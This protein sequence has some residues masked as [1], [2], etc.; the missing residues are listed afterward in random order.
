Q[1]HGSGMVSYTIQ[2]R[3]GQASGTQIKAQARVLFN[4]T[5]PQDTNEITD[6]IDGQAPVTTLTATPLT[7]GGSDYQGQGSAQDDAGGSGVKHVTVYVAADGGDFKIWQRQ[8][9]QTSA[10]YNGPAGHT[11]QFL[12][13]ATDNAG[14]REKPPPMLL[15]PDDGS[16]PNLGTVPNVGQTSQDIPLSP[17]PAPAPQP[18]TTPL[19]VEAQRGIPGPPPA[20]GASE[21]HSVLRPFVGSA[22]ATGFAQSEPDLEP[23]TVAPLPDGSEITSGGP[24]IGPLAIAPLPDGSALVSGGAWRNQLFH[25]PRVGGAVGAPLA[26]LPQPIYALAFDPS[27][28]LWAAT[29]G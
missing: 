9:T 18:P 22:Y 12:A 2:P 27:G 8:T 24:G 26:T 25:V 21:F 23:A 6:T 16:Q 17:P 13:L 5:A 10:V 29:G 14:N 15:V 28:N 11:Y 20:A 4:T 19:L 3:A 1:G 7:P